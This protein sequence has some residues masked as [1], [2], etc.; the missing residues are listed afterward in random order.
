MSSKT[1]EP[2]SALEMFK[3]VPV[4]SDTPVKYA[5]F[6][7]DNDCSTISQI[8]EEVSFQVEKWSDTVHAKCTLVN[9]L[10]IKNN[11]KD[12]FL[13]VSRFCQTK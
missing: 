7:G 2:E 1:I 3:R 12:H 5:V 13:V 11:P 9:H 10:Y 6:I 8:R 4:Q